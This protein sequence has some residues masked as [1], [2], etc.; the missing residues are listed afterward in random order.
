MLASAQGFTVEQAAAKAGLSVRTV[1]RRRAEPAF[2][3]QVRQARAEM[4]ERQA[5]LLTT[6]GFGAIKVLGE[7]L[8]DA[9]V[10]IAERWRMAIQ[11]L[12]QG[13]KFRGETDLEQRLQAVEEVLGLEG[14]RKSAGPQPRQPRG[15]KGREA[16]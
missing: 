9:A 10:P 14:D 4:V 15:G 5:G 16:A 6:L 13:P 7:A 12:S 11:V 2:R 3:Q 8:Q 1:Y